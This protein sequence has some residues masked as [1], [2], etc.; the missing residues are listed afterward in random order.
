[1]S[2]GLDC[3]IFIYQNISTDGALQLEERNS[4]SLFLPD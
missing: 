3:L 1:M 4:V 2:L